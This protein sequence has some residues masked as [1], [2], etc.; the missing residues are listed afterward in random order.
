R[1]YVGDRHDR[2][3]TDVP[4]DA[5]RT[6][7]VDVLKKL[8]PA[9]RIHGVK[10]AVETHADLTADEMLDLIDA[11]GTELVGVTLDTGNLVMRLDDPVR[12]AERLAPFVLATHLKDAV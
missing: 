8:A 4:W 2:F 6:A 5:Q 11:V 10:V 3:R 1:A 9:L 7:T 12:T